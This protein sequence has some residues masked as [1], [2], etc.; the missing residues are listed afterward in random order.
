MH[1]TSHTHKTHTHTGGGRGTVNEQVVE[2][3]SRAP[4]AVHLCSFTIQQHATHHSIQK[5][6]RKTD[7][8]NTAHRH[9]DM[10]GAW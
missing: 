1:N 3:V 4:A 5:T 9:T 8:H 10:R 6:A 7:R 2:V